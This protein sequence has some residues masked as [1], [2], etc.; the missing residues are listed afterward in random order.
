MSHREFVSGIQMAMK[1][2]FMGI[3]PHTQYIDQSG[4]PQFLLPDGASPI[5]ELV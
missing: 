1:L 5:R 2:A 3:D 4:R